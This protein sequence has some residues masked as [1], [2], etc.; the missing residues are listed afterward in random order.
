MPFTKGMKKPTN[1]GAKKGNPYSTLNKT[2]KELL[3][4]AIIELNQD[5]TKPYALLTWGKA[6]PDKFYPIA[7]KLIPTELVAEIKEDMSIISIVINDEKV[8][9]Q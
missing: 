9:L 6:N 1:S 2:F 7:S 8:K 5:P 4:S 3:A